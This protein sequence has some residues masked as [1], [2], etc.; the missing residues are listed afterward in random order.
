M[1]IERSRLRSPLA[2][3]VLSLLHERP[4]HVYEMKTLMRE[5]GHDNVVKLTGGSIYD[6]LERLEK[7]GLVKQARTSR[8]GRRPE[9][10]VYAISDDGELEVQD[11]IRDLISRP[12]NE[13][14]EFAA[15]LAF[16]LNL[17]RKEEVIQLLE[18]RA[19]LLE[20]D[21]AGREALVREAVKAYSAKLP[22]I[23]MIET[24]FQ[25]AMRRA[26]LTWVRKTAKELRDGT[27]PWPTRRQ[28][29]RVAAAEERRRER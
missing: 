5:R 2:L 12:V 14:P 8:H 16:V 9:R 7:A 21:I 25:Q 22:R 4:M 20:A 13:Y 11:W 28:L 6:M 26:E 29:K 1:A 19:G 18:V 27:F 24:E 17:D 10:T 15:A 3:A 23:V